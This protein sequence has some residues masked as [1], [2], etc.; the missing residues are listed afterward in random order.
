[1]SEDR[2][3]H[4]R[5]EDSED[6]AFSFAEMRERL[7]DS[8]ADP[9]VDVPPSLEEDDPSD[10]DS[11]FADLLSEIS[12]QGDSSAWDEVDDEGD[13]E[14]GGLLSDPKSQAIIELL[15]D[16]KNVL[17]LGPLLC[18]AD[19]EVGATLTGG[20]DGDPFNL[21]L[22][23]FSQSPDER[24]QVCR[25][26]QKAVPAETRIVGVGSQTR[27]GSSGTIET[28]DGTVSV[29]VVSNPEDLTRVGIK[30]DQTLNR[31]D[32]TDRR[33][34]LCF[35]SLS[36]LLQFVE[37]ERRVFRFLSILR[38]RIQKSNGHAHYHMEDG[39]HEESLVALIRPLFDAV[40]RYDE[41]GSVSVQT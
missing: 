3:D 5:F 17:L 6:S 32:E 10:D 13:W 38:G 39:A 40:I 21:L 37:D 28:R 20:G 14:K 11:Y 15:G 35:H 34:V 7:D 9:G 23:T 22:V 30:I 33:I 4:R 31:W 19:Y 29:D 24:L 27:S 25:A 1:M 36:A 41:S 16:A 12:G 2:E 26:Y 8:E 18:P